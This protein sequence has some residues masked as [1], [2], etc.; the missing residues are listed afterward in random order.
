MKTYHLDPDKLKVQIRNIYLMYG[1]TLVIL[2][3]LNYFM[4]RGR[5]INNQNW[6][7]LGLIVLMFVVVGWN[8]VRQRKAIWDQ[9]ELT[10]D[11]TG[12][13]QKQP[14][15]ADMFLPRSE[16]TGV[17]ESKYGMTLMVKEQQPVMGIPKMLNLA[18]YEEIK[19]IVEGWLRDAKPV[20]LDV[21]EVEDVQAVL[22]ED[23]P[24]LEALLEPEV[25]PIEE[26]ELQEP[27]ESPEA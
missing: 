24:A 15:A 20:V 10:V 8:S 1:I 17:R 21:E 3:I 19:G 16:I 4:S 12:I 6:L 11:E 5:E 7:T 25:L 2:L 9:Y 14:K 23:Q 26:P 22:P 27:P 18:D 13:G